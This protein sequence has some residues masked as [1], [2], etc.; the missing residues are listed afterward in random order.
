MK[1]VKVVHYLAKGMRDQTVGRHQR[2]TVEWNRDRLGH[3]RL[4][5]PGV[6]RDSWHA[7]S[8]YSRASVS[9]MSLQELC[10]LVRSMR[11]LQRDKVR[12]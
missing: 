8:M 12:H 6:L 1:T 7:G 4:A 3:P 9:I 2:E 5:K 11:A 10:E